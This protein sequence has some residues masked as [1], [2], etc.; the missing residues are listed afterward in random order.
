MC[1]E[2]PFSGNMRSM[3]RFE[4]TPNPEA[5][6]IAKLADEAKRL[7]SSIDLKRAPDGHIYAALD[8]AQIRDMAE[9]KR[10]IGKIKAELHRRR[11]LSERKD[12]IEDA[13]ALEESHPKEEDGENPA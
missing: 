3:E 9:R 1:T 12:L 11:P 2:N 13:R 7:A 5:A 8:Q 4:V 6:R 10:M